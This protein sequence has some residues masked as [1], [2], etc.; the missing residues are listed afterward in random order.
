M[1]QDRI[2]SGSPS[3][4]ILLTVWP[5]ESHVRLF[6]ALANELRSRGHRVV[7]YLTPSPEWHGD[8]APFLCFPYRN[9]DAAKIEEIL[10]KLSSGH[11]GR[12]ETRS[13]WKE[14]LVESIPAQVADL[15]PLIANCRPDL[16]VTDITMW[17][18]FLILHELMEIP[19]VPYAHT[20][21][22]LLPG[23]D[24]PL[25]GFSGPRLKSRVLRHARSRVAA[26]LLGVANRGLRNRVNQLR[27]ECSLEPIPA[28]VTEFSG[29]MP[30]YLVPG[31][32]E[33]DY[34]REDL[35][36]SVRYVG[37]PF[38]VPR[39]A[40]RLGPQQIPEESARVIIDSGLPYT[41]PDFV[42]QVSSAIAP[43]GLVCE[44]ANANTLGSTL[45]RTSVVI[46]DANSPMVLTA[47]GDGIPLV[48]IPHSFDS[49]ENAWRVREYNCGI[50]ISPQKTDDAAIRDAVTRILREP[51]YRERAHQL[52][53]NFEAQGGASMAAK[54]LEELGLSHRWQRKTG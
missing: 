20:A 26:Q 43:L 1:M 15:K 23:P 53:V 5:V 34:Q 19:V 6:L 32:Q 30:L 29:S 35:P 31:S 52:A 8:L 9:V 50:R 44:V 37:V 47:L 17:A 24:G 28:S 4:S 16:I 48:A 2:S 22:C 45:H 7:F 36:K 42:E 38:G 21:H 51:S 13:L 3:L 41:R 27:R 33:F 46:T 40:A 39:Q 11:A 10:R 12:W 14:F 25:V 49:G 54:L 18:P